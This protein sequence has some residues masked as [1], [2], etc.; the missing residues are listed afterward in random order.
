MAAP[1]LKE[2]R[3]PEDRIALNTAVETA[4]LCVRKDALACDERFEYLQLWREN[5]KI[6]VSPDLQS[7]FR[8]ESDDSRRSQRRHRYGFV[9][10]DVDSFNHC[11][12]KIDHAGNAAGKR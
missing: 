2:R 8:F 10:R 7:T 3:S 5:D 4:A 1:S 9:E 12:D 11:A 6:G